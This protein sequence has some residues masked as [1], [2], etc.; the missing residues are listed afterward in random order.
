[1]VQ[2]L[3]EIKSSGLSY[4]TDSQPGI[5]RNGK[6]GK[7]YYTDKDGKRTDDEAQLSRIKSLVLPPAWQKVWIAPKKNAYLQATGI[8]AAGRK[9]YRYH[10]EW[11]SRRSDSKYFRLLEFGK[12]LPKARKRIAKDLRRKEFD[13]QKVLAIS[14]QVMLKT[15]IRVGNDAYKELY[16]SYGL[17]T[18]TNKHV[19]IEGNKLKLTFKGKKGVQQNVQ[20][21]DKTLA[22]LIRQCKEIPGQDLFQYYTEGNEHRPIDSGRINNYIREITGSDFTAKDFR[23]WGGTLEALRQLAICCSN[24]DQEKPKKKVIVEVLDCV[25]GK[26]GNTRAVCKSSYV[27]PL[28]LEAFENDQLA[29]YLKKVNKDHSESI[30][31]VENDE[32]VLMQF[33]RAAQKK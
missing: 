28:L 21:N 18:L 24:D 16:G 9:Q 3:E 31:A 6:P 32:K 33:L 11:T 10:P 20:L 8:D 26:L 1:M 15:L 27:Y 23:T 30:K 7:F 2:T 25:A 12:V 22:K 5:Y 14:M 13:E 17:T 29:K 19:K 4:V